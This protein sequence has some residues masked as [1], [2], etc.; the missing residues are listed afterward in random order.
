MFATIN[1]MQ[2]FRE[3]ADAGVLVFPEIIADGS[4]HD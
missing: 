3:R 1:T 4:V 2:M